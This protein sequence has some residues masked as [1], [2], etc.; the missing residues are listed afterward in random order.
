[1]GTTVYHSA[2]KGTTVHH[3]IPQW[4]TIYKLYQGVTC[5]T[6]GYHRVPHG[7]HGVPHGYHGVPHG[8]HGVPHGYHGYPDTT[9]PLG[10]TVPGTKALE[11]HSIWLPLGTPG[12]PGTCVYHGIT[13]PLGITQY[14]SYHRIPWYLGT[15]MYYSA[16]RGTT[17]HGSFHQ[18]VQSLS[19]G[20][21]GAIF[22]IY[23]EILNFLFF[24][25]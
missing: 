8:Y 13:A 22:M 9:V 10:T 21:K 15:T 1:M 2:P 11:C 5:S 4:T 6:T 20:I 3:G 23:I 16:P 18:T 19:P 17:V 12:Y 7:Y 14:R 24:T 25:I